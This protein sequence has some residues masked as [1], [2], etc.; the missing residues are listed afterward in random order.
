MVSL[1]ALTVA[2]LLTPDSCSAPAGNPQGNLI[3]PGV[4]G[5]I[6]YDGRYSLDAYAP[7]GDPRPAAVIIHGSSGIRVLTSINSF[8]SWIRRASPGLR[9]T[10][11]RRRT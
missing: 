3:T 1:L 11:R 9:S 5:D 6:S 10:M 8:R 4:L 2:L 7:N